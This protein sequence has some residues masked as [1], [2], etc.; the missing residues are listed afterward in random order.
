M[1]N[2]LPPIIHHYIILTKIFGNSLF[3]CHSDG[4]MR[5]FFHSRS[6]TILYQ[7]EKNLKE[8]FFPSL[9]PQKINKKE[10]SIRS[11]NKWDICRIYLISDNRFKGKVTVGLSSITG[12]F[13]CNSANIVYIIYCKN[14]RGQCVGS[15]TD[16]KSR[17]WSHTSYINSKKDVC[18]S[19][20]FF[21]N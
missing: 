12:S 3:M 8:L 1:L 20:R 16:C 15:A 11:C 14:W 17:N 13:S 21:K 5:K 4:D 6:L 7:Q 2:L 9:S 10:C 19:G 18:G